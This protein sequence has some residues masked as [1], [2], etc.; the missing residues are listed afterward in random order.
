MSISLD[1]I[2]NHIAY[3]TCTV[4]S[5]MRLKLHGVKVGHN[6]KFAGIPYVSQV[7]GSSIQVGDSC[8]FMSCKTGNPFGINHKCILT[9]GK[10]GAKIIIGNNCGFSGTTIMCA[11]SI[12][13]QD[14]VRCGA[15]T[16]LMDHD[17]HWDDFRSGGQKPIVIEDNVWLG[18]NSIIMKD[19]KIGRYA[20]VGAGSVVRSNVPPYAIVTGNPA[21]IVG[22]SKTPDEIIEFETVH[23]N[24]KDRIDKV[25]L[26][27]NY[28]K[29]FLKR[30]DIIKNYL[31]I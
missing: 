1:D 18:A 16:V 19:V 13:V 24:E 7:R 12:I 11:N 9:A 14:N 30:L 5:I 8:R 10:I 26:E 4:P 17:G 29:F 15:N 20:M 25:T 2:R 21:K 31:R 27:K 23:Y 6:N 22:F 3:L 28:N